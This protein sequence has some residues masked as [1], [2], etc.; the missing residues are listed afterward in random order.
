MSLEVSN[1]DHLGLVAGIIDEIGI[2]QKINQL[3]GSSITRKN[4]RGSSGKRNVVK[5]VR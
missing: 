5:W 3:R 2:E 4:H 1:I